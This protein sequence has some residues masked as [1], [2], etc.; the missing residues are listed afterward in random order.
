MS[1]EGASSVPPERNSDEA[2]Q[3]SDTSR[4]DWEINAEQLTGT[5]I[6]LL[7]VLL[8]VGVS[9]GMGMAGPW[10]LRVG[11][12]LLTTIALVVVVKV[13]TTTG[14]GPVARAARWAVT[15]DRR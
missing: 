5:G 2:G 15:S 8:S 14:R 12:G 4:E 10:W 9:I 7:G 11:A 1:T 3:Q 6:T 13:S